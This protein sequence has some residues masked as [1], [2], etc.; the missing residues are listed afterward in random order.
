MNLLAR[1]ALFLV[2][3]LPALGS[4]QASD[5]PASPPP[6]LATA[7]PELPPAAQEPAPPSFQGELIPRQWQSPRPDYSVPRILA[8]T[9]LGTLAGAGG[10]VGGFLLGME[11]EKDCNPFDD[12]CS[13]D[14]ILVQ[15]APAALATGL[16]SSLVVYGMGSALHGEGALSTTMVGGSV[17]TG[18]G[19][20]LSVAA[21]SYAGILLIPPLAALGAAIAYELS[22][23]A[24]EREHARARLGST[25]LQWTPVVS[26]TPGGGMLGGLVGRF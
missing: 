2:V 18:L 23:S 21:Q 13:S 24:W 17:G 3:G 11:L 4:A 15:T 19:L 6:P 20:L 22:D 9:F 16:L 10:M 7:P 12:V 8:G 14:E 26:I 1:L 25:P 5:A